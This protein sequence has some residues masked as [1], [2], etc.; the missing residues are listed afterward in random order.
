MWL[1]TVWSFQS[2]DKFEKKLK[3]A[4][5]QIKSKP[6]SGRISSK[7]ENVRSI[8]VTKHNRI[9]YTITGD[10]ITLLELFETKQSPDKNKYK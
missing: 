3:K 5:E 4:I 7:Y 2:A 9:V 10:T 8:L 6:F 1:E